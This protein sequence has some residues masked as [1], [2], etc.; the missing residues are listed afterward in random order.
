MTYL[1]L[2]YYWQ[3]MWLSRS[4]LLRNLPCAQSDQPQKRRRSQYQGEM[5]QVSMVFM[6]NV[7]GTNRLTMV[8]THQGKKSLFKQQLGTSV[9][10]RFQLKCIVE[11]CNMTD[12]KPLESAPNTCHTWS[13]DTNSCHIDGR[14]IVI[15]QVCSNGICHQP[16]KLWNAVK[17]PCSGPF[18]HGCRQVLQ[19]KALNPQSRPHWTTSEV[20]GA[21]PWEHT[22]DQWV[23]RM[24]KTYK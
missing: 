12:W 3:T 22:S 6:E 8:V 9:S 7:Q 2:I 20:H 13:Y 15:P 14:Y 16:G 24:D 10:K 4:R 11:W 17:S 1:L 5:R 19:S 21:K 18:T 23:E